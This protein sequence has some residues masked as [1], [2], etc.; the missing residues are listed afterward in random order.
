[1]SVLNKIHGDLVYPRRILR[2]SKIIAELLPHGGRVLDVGCGDGLLS[3]EISKLRAD[4]SLEGIDVLV[5]RNTLIAV[6]G[7]D[8]ESIPH[9]EASFDVVMMVDVLHHTRDPRILLREAK[10]VS[11][12]AIVIKDHTL[13]GPLAGPKLRLMDWVGNARHGVTLP[14]NYWPQAKWLAEI[15]ALG[16]RLES[17][18]EDL[19]LYPRWADWMFGGSLHFIARL[20]QVRTRSAETVSGS[21]GS[22]PPTMA[23]HN[24]PDSISSIARLRAVY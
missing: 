9:A 21:L 11:S 17:W 3:S 10:R 19:A 16:L 18:E 15:K 14:Y 12:L 20:A 8:G 5:R 22:Q 6:T 23:D 13:D 24:D 7:F 2:L 1:M 4:V